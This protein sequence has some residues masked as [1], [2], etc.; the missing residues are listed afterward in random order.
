[1][2]DGCARD[3]GATHREIPSNNRRRLDI[4]LEFSSWVM[5]HGVI[6]GSTLQ[7][8]FTTGLET[9]ADILVVCGNFYQK[10]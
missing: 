6:V 4:R 7:E 3:S 9:L 2:R 5:W 8:P 10:T 1:M